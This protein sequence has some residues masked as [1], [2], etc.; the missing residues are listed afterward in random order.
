MQ[1]DTSKKAGGNP[2]VFI[3]GEETV[4]PWVIR[5]TDYCGV[6]PWE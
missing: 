3:A 5:D 1:E 6:R 4:S 2:E